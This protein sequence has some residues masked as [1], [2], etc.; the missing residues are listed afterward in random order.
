MD[1]TLPRLQCTFCALHGFG[2]ATGVRSGFLSAAKVI[3][4]VAQE[5][6]ATADKYGRPQPQLVDVFAILRYPA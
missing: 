1:Q 2:F 3:D 4:P 5:S 6:R